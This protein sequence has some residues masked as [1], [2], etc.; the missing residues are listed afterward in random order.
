MPLQH[1]NII[2]NMI[3]TCPVRLKLYYWRFLI[4]NIL[5]I[6]LK[7]VKQFERTVL[8][9]KCKESWQPP[10]KAVLAVDDCTPDFEFDRPACDYSYV[11]AA[12]LIDVDSVTADRGFTSNES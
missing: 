6:T 3:S 5:T 4:C 7:Q 8:M 11:D 10:Q 12:R 2:K 1:I 9:V